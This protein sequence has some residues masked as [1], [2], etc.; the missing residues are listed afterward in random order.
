MP[1][2]LGTDAIL[3]YTGCYPLSLAWTRQD[4]LWLCYPCPEHYQTQARRRRQAEGAR[5]A[6]TPSGLCS[7]ASL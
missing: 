7:Q 4:L 2:S 1:Q 3:A 6:Q 5:R